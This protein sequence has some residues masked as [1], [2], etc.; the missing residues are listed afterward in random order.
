MNERTYRVPRAVR[1]EA[2]RSLSAFTGADPGDGA[3]L[4]MAQ[5]LTS[6]TPVTRATVENIGRFFSAFRWRSPERSQFGLYGG[7]AGR[8]WVSRC[9]GVMAHPAPRPLGTEDFDM[10][11]PFMQMDTIEGDPDEHFA[12]N[13]IVA[14]DRTTGTKAPSPFGPRPGLVVHHRPQPHPGQA[15]VVVVEPA[16][17]VE[18][19]PVEQEIFPQDPQAD[20]VVIVQRDGAVSAFQQSLSQFQQERESREL[21][22]RRNALMATFQPSKDTHLAHELSVFRDALVESFRAD[23]PTWKV[24]SRPV[25]ADGAPPTAAPPAA[26]APEAGDG[27]DGDPKAGSAGTHH[28]KVQPRDWHGR[29]AKVGA[30]VSH[31]DGVGGYISKIVGDEVVVTNDDGSEERMKAREVM[32]QTKP[33][34]ARLSKPLPLIAD[35]GARLD[36]YLQAAV[37]GGAG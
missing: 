10:D 11:A 28:S 13:L 16:G 35:L 3:A 21:A 4:G 12:I 25:V 37:A 23:G 26:P 33:G 14:C 8:D 31:H 5:V 7:A 2:Q 20:G 34:R 27:G 15:A 6:G 29:F 24:L 19:Q 18:E 30:R 36:S 9:L 22:D 1:N 17:P 32:V